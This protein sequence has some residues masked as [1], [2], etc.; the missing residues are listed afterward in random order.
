MHATAR[1][2]RRTARRTRHDAIVTMCTAML[3]LVALGACADATTE[4]TVR[5]ASAAV[6]AARDVV[7]E[8]TSGPWS[9][10]VEGETGP[11]ALHSFHI[12]RDWNGTVVHYAHGFRDA[13]PEPDLRDQDGLFALRERLGALGYAVAVSSYATNGFAVKDGAQRVHQLRGLI[14]AELPAPADRH[15]L[16]GHSLG[17]A[18]ALDLAERYP[19]QYDGAL[20]LC[21]MVGGSLAQTQYLGHVRALFDF[22]YPNVVPGSVLGVP[23][24]TTV[25]LAQVV[26]AVQQNPMGLFAIGSTAQTPLPYVPSGAVTN[27]QS[28]AFQTLVGSLFGAVSF[29]VRGVNDLVARVH[30]KSAFGNDDTE[31]TLGTPLLPAG[32]IAPAIA[33]AQAGVARYELAPSARNYL[34]HHFAPSGELRIPVLTL[35]NTWDPAVPLF[36]ETLL[37]E[38]VEA[39]GATPF[40]LQ[41]QVPTY[42]HCAITGDQV[43]QGVAALT[44]WIAS[45][46]KPAA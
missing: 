15:V 40:L 10:I 32:A 35:H 5:S 31:Y 45:G 13:G 29:Q 6:R 21:G 4:P 43:M 46:V 3:S 11:G 19:T 20:L 17:G 22:H 12:P 41:R 27:P 7:V 38:R 23:A 2:F 34:T 8:P 36:H 30:G 28:L 14:A 26:A 1:S 33:A 44:G 39:A 42:G 37:R 24:G 9:R 18:V 16:V 25:T